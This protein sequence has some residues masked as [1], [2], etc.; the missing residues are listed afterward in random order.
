M[1]KFHEDD[2]PR[3]IEACKYYR[4]STGSEYL[5]DKYSELINKLKIYAEQN[6]SSNS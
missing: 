1:Y 4:E 2:I 5:Y 3:L 6:H